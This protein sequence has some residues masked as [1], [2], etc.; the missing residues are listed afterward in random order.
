[1][2][3]VLTVTLIAMI[4]AP[5]VARARSFTDA[6]DGQS[7]Q[8]PPVTLPPSP[9]PPQLRLAPAPPPLNEA[10]WGRW[11]L[12]SR[13]QGSRCNKIAAIT[14]GLAAVGLAAALK[15]PLNPSPEDL[16]HGRTGKRETFAHTVGA[17][18]ALGGG[19]G[20]MTSARCSDYSRQIVRELELEGRRRGFGTPVPA[21]MTS[22]DWVARIAMARAQASS[23]KWMTMGGT[24][25][26]LAAGAAIRDYQPRPD[27]RGAARLGP[28]FVVFMIGFGSTIAGTTMW[29]WNAADVRSL[30]RRQPPPGTTVSIAPTA[31]GF[32]IGAVLRF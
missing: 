9:Y 12:R 11:L 21:A 23:G 29:A 22:R 3:R 27:Q 17:I 30:E 5:A 16:A 1:M 28:G 26:M 13:E 14:G 18:T 15:N 24:A 7:R 19:L 31:G 6:A 8:Y 2:R 10:E 32:R 25:A 4:A 20:F